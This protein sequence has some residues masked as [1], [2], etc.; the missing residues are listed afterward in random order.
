VLPCCQ[1]AG[2]TGECSTPAPPPALPRQ[3]SAFDQLRG[4]QA[5]SDG[6][7]ASLVL[8]VRPSGGTWPWLRAFP[9]PDKEKN[10]KTL[11]LA[12][13]AATLTLAIPAAL[14]ARAQTSST[15]VIQRDQPPPSGVVIE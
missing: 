13:S 2:N 3:A 9:C 4:F 5:C 7:G 11:A 15:T 10:M 1:V 12:L 6:R 8:A 14:P